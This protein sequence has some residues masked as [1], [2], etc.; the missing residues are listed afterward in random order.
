MV[1]RRAPAANYAI[2]GMNFAV[3]ALFNLTRNPD[4][5][6]FRERYLILDAEWPHLFQFFTY[7]F[8]HGGIMHLLGNML[9]LWVFGNSVNAKMGDVAYFVFYLAGGVFA[10]TAFAFNDT[11]RLLGAS[12]SIAAVTTAYLVLFPRSRVTVMYVFFFIGFFELPATL[13]ILLKIILWDNIIAPT[14]HPTGIESVAFSAHIGGYAFGFVAGALLLAGRAIPRDHFD[15]LSLFDRWNRRRAFQTAMADPETRR[16]AEYGTV[17]RAPTLSKA[18]QVAEEAKF[19][20]IS[21]LRAQISLLLDQGDTAGAA[22]TYEEL[23]ML[24]PSQC[25]SARNQLTIARE[26]YATGRTPQAASA[27]ERY[28]KSYPTGYEADEMRLL[29]GIIYARD[30]QRFQEAEK[31]LVASLGR[32]TGDRKDQCIQWLETVRHSLGKAAPDA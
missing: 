10:A 14:M 9:F 8:S 19:D 11:N 25:L 15:M 31:H 6:L 1:A 24:D 28:L 18:E 21:A 16:R 3:F 5:E 4:F 20:A 27:F 23:A 12:G 30:L 17:A 7:Q 29:L 22:R 26:F 13:L 32:L 2:I